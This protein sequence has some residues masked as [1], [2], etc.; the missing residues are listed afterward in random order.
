MVKIAVLGASSPFTT[1]LFHALGAEAWF[2]GASIALYG[3]RQDNLALMREFATHCLGGK[4]C[5]VS[6][7]PD[8]QTAL[9]EADV[10]INQ[11]RFGG[12][13]GR[14]GDEGV[15]IVG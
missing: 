4:G 6:T 10:V 1:G 11:I 9:Q 12:L 7:T 14:A 8:L 3:R 5:H 15:P 13:G 2:K